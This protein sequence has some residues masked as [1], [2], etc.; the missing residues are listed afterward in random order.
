MTYNFLR[1]AVLYTLGVLPAGLVAQQARDANGGVVIAGGLTALPDA[2]STQ[3][4]S[5]GGPSGGTGG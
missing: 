2:L 3:C 4:G 5:L 1:T